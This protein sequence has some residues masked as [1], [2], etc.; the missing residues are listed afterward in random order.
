MNLFYT[1][2][3]SVL[4]TVHYIQSYVGWRCETATRDRYHG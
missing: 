2:L 4:I 3:G 1:F